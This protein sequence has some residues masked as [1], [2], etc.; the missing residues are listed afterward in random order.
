MWDGQWTKWKVAQFE[1]SLEA[2]QEMEK[3][4]WK[5]WKK[6]DE[7]FEKLNEPFLFGSDDNDM[8]EFQLDH[9]IGWRRFQLEHDIGHNMVQQLK[10]HAKNSSQRKRR[11]QRKKMAVKIV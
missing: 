3:D 2:K 4:E 9:D 7:E 5:L 6:T 1:E 10:P 11:R 8:E